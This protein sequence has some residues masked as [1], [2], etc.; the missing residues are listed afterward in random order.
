MRRIKPIPTLI[1]L[2]CILG[3]VGY[4]RRADERRNQVITRQLPPLPTASPSPTLQ[5]WASSDGKDTLT[6]RASA[7]DSG[8]IS[9]D[10]F[11]ESSG[12]PE[13]ARQVF[14]H[15][16]T[17]ETLYEIP[18]NSWS[19]TNAYFFLKQK[20]ATGSASLVLKAN[21]EAFSNDD[22]VLNVNQFF[23]EKLPDYTLKDVTGWAGPTLLLVNTTP[24]DQTSKGVSF[25][26]DVTTRRFTRLSSNFN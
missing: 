5:T 16:T 12:K 4:F 21:G 2:L 11:V 9:Y 17:S 8:Q 23:A 10:F 14:S 24:T 13:T 18:F 1:L 15:V 25:W 20:D 3:I 19:P 26:F 6:M 7:S 22:R